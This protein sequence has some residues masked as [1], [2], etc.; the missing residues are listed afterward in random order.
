VNVGWRHGAAAVASSADGP[1]DAAFPRRRDLLDP[2]RVA[3]AVAEAGGMRANGGGRPADRDR[4]LDVY[5]YPGRTLQAVHRIGAH[6]LTVHAA[7]VGVALP[8]TTEDLLLPGLHG[9]AR[10]FP[11]D[12]GLP[13]LAS[14]HAEL[15]PDADLLTYLPGQRCVLGG[16]DRVAKVR[17]AAETLRAHHR[18]VDLWATP[19]RAFR[20]ARPL[21]IDIGRAVRWE[22][23]I[24]G[25]GV[26]S[27]L[28]EMPRTELAGLVAVGL[29]GLHALDLDS[30]AG[31]DLPDLGADQL[32]DRLERKTL[33]TIGRALP[34][35]AGRSAAL[36]GALRA[37][38]PPACG[39]ATAVHGDFHIANLL[40]DADGLV[41]LDLDELSRGDA[42]LDLAL[43]ASRLLLVALH[44]GDGLG[45]AARLVAELTD[46][47]GAARGWAVDERS[48]A[49]YLATC[50]IGRQVKTS[51]R[52]LAPDLEGLCSSLLSLAE[53]TLAR[54]AFDV[55]TVERV[56][57]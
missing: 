51:I 21:G 29:A 53:H 15:G 37:A 3:A 57:A 42:E 7:P 45:E 8:S 32:L 52:H 39:P 5:Y 49:W 34:G 30:S 19:G 1:A 22:Q 54:G 43:F 55:A 23:R 44:R 11:A 6:I 17:T 56:A 27:C 16:P 38:G 46:A 20:M 4:L 24:A 47:Y 18:Q 14:V 10:L 40:L 2:A 25:R 31:R 26:E 9:V 48:F 28:G 12:P 13:S 35:L 33:R 36:A 50:L 41:L